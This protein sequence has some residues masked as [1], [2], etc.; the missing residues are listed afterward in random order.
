MMAGARKHQRPQAPPVRATKA[1]EPSLLSP[2]P[3][4]F[5]TV[6]WFSFLFFPDCAILKCER[7]QSEA[8]LGVVEVGA[9]TPTRSHSF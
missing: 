4:L 5:T 8:A 1:P 3:V 7:N 9:R 6:L 2:D